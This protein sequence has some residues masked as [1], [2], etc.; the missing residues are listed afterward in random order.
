MFSASGSQTLICIK[1]FV[2]P[3]LSGSQPP[4][5]SDSVGVG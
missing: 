4:T 3:E 1:G 5:V 2:K